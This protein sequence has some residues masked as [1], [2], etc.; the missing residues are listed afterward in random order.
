MQRTFIAIGRTA[1]LMTFASLMIGGTIARGDSPS[2]PTAAAATAAPTTKETS[3]LE[4]G[5]DQSIIS[6][7]VRPGNDFYQYANEVWLKETKI[8]SDKSNYGIFTVLDDLTKEQVRSLIE[9]AAT[10]ENAAEGSAAQKVGDMYNSVMDTERRNAAGIKPIGPLLQRI[11][12]LRDR[13]QLGETLGYLSQH[14]VGQFFAAYVNVDKKNSDQYAVYLYQSGLTMPDRDYY[15]NNESRFETYRNELTVYIADLLQFIGDE[16]NDAAAEAVLNVEREIAEIHWTRTENR[17]PVRTYN[18]RTQAE[19][20]EMLPALG[21]AEMAKT[22]GFHE[23]PTLIISQLSFFEKIDS[24]VEKTPLE[25]I[26]AYLAFKVMDAYA[27]ELTEELE[28]RHFAFHGGVLS[29]VT[30]QQ[31]LW[32]RAVDKTSGTV[33][34]LV[35][36]LYVDKHFKPAAKNRMKQLVENLKTAFVG[37]I[38]TRD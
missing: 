8:P 34:E 27:S 24:L 29:G 6:S 31:P 33:G 14:G 26:R 18:K 32:K 1:S 13:D 20:A 25:T 7:K 11:A 12:S 5:I 15:L 3:T 2:D 38:N 30:E 21:F 37:R 35:G 22:L 28:Q 4:S 19:V 16:G 36:Q 23:Q 17:D 10:D 9:A